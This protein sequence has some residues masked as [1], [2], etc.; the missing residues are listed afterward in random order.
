MRRSVEIIDLNARGLYEH[1]LELVVDLAGG[2]GAFAPLVE[3]AAHRGVA[4]LRAPVGAESF[5]GA[6]PCEPGGLGFLLS[7]V[8]SARDP[9]YR[10][11][12]RKSWRDHRDDALAISALCARLDESAKWTMRD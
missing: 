3:Y 6:G 4:V 1:G 5:A 8:R 9:D 11:A 12:L 10:E 2:V 7:A